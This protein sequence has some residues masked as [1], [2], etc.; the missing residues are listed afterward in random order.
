MFST[1]RG[2]PATVRTLFA[3]T[4]IN[5]IGCMVTPFMVFFLASRGVTGAETSLILGALG[6]G[7]LLGPA[8]GG[9]L[10]DRIGRRPTMLIGLVGTAAAQGAL[11]LAPGVAL[12]AA[13]ALLVSATNAM[14]SPAVYALMADSVDGPHRRQAYALFGWGINIGTSIAGVLGGFLAAHGYWLLFAVDAASMLAYALVVATR[15]RETR[16]AARGAHEAEASGVVAAEVTATGGPEAAVT[17]AGAAVTAAGAAGAGAGT[18]VK[19]TRGPGAGY[20]IVVRDRLML[21]VLPVLGVQSFVYALTEAALPLAISGSGLSPTVYGTLGAVNAALVVLLQPLVTTRLAHLPQ[22]SVHAAGSV[23]VAV[24]V[25]M[26]GLADGVAGF[27]VSVVVWSLGEVVVA[28]ISATVISHLAPPHAR[29]RYQG[30]LNWTWGVARFTALTVGVLLY[31]AA[32]PAV[33]WW[34]ALVAGVT[35]SALSLGLAR[36]VTARTRHALAA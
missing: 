14:V 32:G 29:G 17:A 9:L 18:A 22:L 20:G 35:A 34:T 25:A 36:R 4:I 23:L 26:T 28:G 16:P 11:F 13:A 1:L 30:A 19:G 2:L 33:L 21:L 31:T 15:L 12:M 3:G 6:A 8:V 7:G 24:G 27:V 10:A 5:R